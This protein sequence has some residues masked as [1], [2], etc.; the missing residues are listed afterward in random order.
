MASNLFSSFKNKTQSQFKQ[1]VQVTPNVEFGSRAFFDNMWGEFGKQF[2]A[3]A[4]K[5]AKPGEAKRMGTEAAGVV[6]SAAALT[7]PMATAQAALAPL[8][9]PATSTRTVVDM[10]NNLLSPAIKQIVNSINIVEPIQTR[11]NVLAGS[12]QGGE[13]E[14]NYLQ[15]VTGGLNVSTATGSDAYSKLAF[16]AKGTKLEGEGIRELFEGISASIRTMNLGTGDPSLIFQAYTQILAKGKLSMEELRQQLGEKFP[17][18]MQVFAKA[19]NVSVPELGTL[20]SKG[21]ILSEDILPKVAKILNQDFGEAAKAASG[22]FTSAM[23][24]MENAGFNLRVKLSDTFSSVFSVVADAGAKGVQAFTNNFDA[25]SKVVGLGLLGASVQVAVGI[26]ALLAAPMIGKHVATAQNFVMSAFTKSLSTLTPFFAGVFI[27]LLDDVLGAKNSVIDNL[28]NGILNGIDAIKQQADSISRT[29]FNKSLFADA[30]NSEDVGIIQNVNGALSGVIQSVTNFRNAI[31]SGV[32]EMGALILMF[33]QFIALG[34][35]YI[36]PVFSNIGNALKGMGTAFKE[37]VTNSDNLKGAFKNIF[38]TSANLGVSALGKL[39]FVALEAAVALGVLALARGDFSDPIGEAFTKS[40]SKIIDN[41]KG[42]E[43]SLKSLQDVGKDV[44]K[45]ITESLNLQSKGAELNLGK[46]LGISADS[47]KTDDLFKA[48]NNSAPDGA[49]SEN[50]RKV[51][52]SRKQEA[53]K[54][55]VGD[56]FSEN[57]RYTTLAQ[58]QVLKNAKD[59]NKF[60]TELQKALTKSSLTPETITNFAKNLGNREAITNITEIDTQIK[61]L[62]DRRVDLGLINTSDSKKQLREVDKQIDDLL[63]TRKSK[64][65]IF[66][67][68]FGGVDDAKNELDKVIKAIDNDDNLP[69]AA[70]RALK[71]PL[72]EQKKQIEDTIKSIDTLGLSKLVKPLEDIWTGV[73]NKLRDADTALEKFQSRL[74]IVGLNNQTNIINAG[75][76]TNASDASIARA[77]TN[78]SLQNTQLQLNATT[79]SQSFRE[80]SLRQLLSVPG[81]DVNESRKKEIDK[82]REDIQKDKQSVA[83][84]SLQVAQGRA[85][86]QKEL[87]DLTK[88]V[89]DYYLNISR[90]AQNTQLEI[91]KLNTQ[92]RNQNMSNRLRSVLSD[93]YDTLIGSIVDGVEQALNNFNSVTDKAL[94]SQQQLLQ[95]SFDIQDAKRGGVELS[96]QIPANI[97]D[98][99]VDLDF[100]SIPSD[101]NIAQ[102]REEV[103]LTIGGSDNLGNSINNVT[104]NVDQLYKNLESVINPILEQERQTDLV[105][106]NIGRTNDELNRAS[107][108]SN[109]WK[110][111]ILP[112]PIQVDSINSSMGSILGTIG[113]LV[114]KTAEWISGLAGAPNLI[115]QVLGLFT[116][117]SNNQSLQIGG[118]G[119]VVQQGLNFL[120]GGGGKAG[121][122]SWVA[123]SSSSMDSDPGHIGDDIFAPIGSK[124]YSPV[125]GTVVQSRVGG[126]KNTDDANPL[127]PGYQPQQLVI[128]K[129][130]MPIEFEGKKITHL[131]MRHLLDRNVEVG[132]KVKMGDLLGTIG[133]AGGKGTQFG[134]KNPGN[135]SDADAAHLHIEYSPAENDQRNSLRD[136]QASRLTARLSQQFKAGVISGQQMTPS[137]PQFNNNTGGVLW[138]KASQFAPSDLSGLTSRGKKAME[139]LKNPN[140]RKVLDAIAIAELGDQAAAKGGYGYLF[141]DTGGKETFN[142]NTLG[143]HPKRRVSAGGHTSSAT[144]RYQT[145][146][147]VWN[148]EAGRLGIKDF[149]PQSQEIMAVSRLMYRQ[150]L[151]QVMRGDIAGAI[152]KKGDFDLAGEWASLEGNPYGQGTVGGK[153]SNFLANVNRAGMPVSIAAN[154]FRSATVPQLQFGVNSG[155]NIAVNTIQQRS[156]AQQANN[157]A[158]QRASQIAGDTALSRVKRQTE[159]ANRDLIDRD[160]ATRRATTDAKFEAIPFPTLK[161]QQLKES[162]E[163]LRQYQDRITETKRNIEDYKR[164]IDQ[165]NKSIPIFQDAIK[166]APDDNTRKSNQVGLDA[167]IASRNQNIESLRV[168]KKSLADQ[169]L[170]FKGKEAARVE[171]AN[172]EEYIRSSKAEIAIQ[173]AKNASVQAYIDSAE[174]YREFNPFDK[175]LDDLPA[176]KQ[177]LAL[178]QLQVETSNKLLQIEEDIKRSGGDS[179]IV[180]EKTKLLTQLEQEYDYKVTQIKL[181]RELHDRELE[182]AR[183]QRDIAITTRFN[184]VANQ[185]TTAKI[186]TVDKSNSLNAFGIDTGELSKL[187]IEEYTNKVSELG[188]NFRKSI[189]EI[190]QDTNL[191]KEQINEL[192]SSTENLNKINLD[193]L[194]QELDNA[195]DTDKIN[196]YSK[197]ID[198]LSNRFTLTRQPILNLRNAQADKYERDGG[199]VFVA[200]ASRRRVGREQEMFNRDQS[201]MQLDRDVLQ[202][203]LK[204]IEV[205]DTEVE[206]LRNSIVEL[207]EIN[208]DNLNNQ[209]KT[210]GV[211]LGDITKNGITQLSQGLAD[212]ITKGGSVGEVFDNLFNNILNQ[213][214]NMGINSLLGGLFGGL[215][216]D[217]GIVGE[218]NSYS[219]NLMNTIKSAA[220][221]ERNLSGKK[222]TLIMAHQGELLVPADRVKELSSMGLGAD[223]LL[224]RTYAY[225]GVVGERSREYGSEMRTGRNNSAIQIEYQSTQIAGQSYVTEE[226]FQEG[227]RRAAEEGGRR[228]AATVENKLSNSPNYRRA[229]GF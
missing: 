148:E 214:L 70:K 138:G 35:L 54:L 168:A 115:Q 2:Q 47:F 187:R 112:I 151:D 4:F 65:K 73:V 3:R 222:P 192:V 121:K 201:L 48:I 193:N 101:N 37:A 132:Q 140:V 128:I 158:Q 11:L 203:K 28:K 157:E 20:I 39:K 147:F 167:S 1:K 226:N 165:A 88:Q 205:P 103:D 108:L 10:L 169:E 9:I 144:G 105:R 92:T 180:A 175:R 199:N 123:N 181:T 80:A 59:I 61:K 156:Q 152:S 155:T 53:E 62:T 216:A 177:R 120:T 117:G 118:L 200:N 16:A 7:A 85:N 67:D 71:A 137:I 78:S 27:D 130:D 149:K 83:E 213:A 23:I 162:T 34:Q 66:D 46:L 217:G 21:A 15:N 60:S 204:G 119:A 93:G 12:T 72:E 227:I 142:P 150:V 194:K 136:A 26:E 220:S 197:V 206:G 126:T 90:N 55:G 107:E 228:G 195:L 17:Q 91:K 219:S 191:T 145:M 106:A 179:N 163:N 94:E 95:S 98:I 13:K 188:L 86:L 87:R 224:N 143:S 97:P 100:S 76:N 111:N 31:P 160:L 208:L 58:E 25:I 44:G 24:R 40:S 69:L 134:S 135:P 202:A 215:F 139:A 210:I 18:A 173:E 56:Y 209:F 68:V 22:N 133:E 74:K 6:F 174:K 159:R 82:L 81:S 154:N 14:L 229:L 8:L 171:K 207:S 57:D 198:N 5:G 164:V 178:E 122:V 170:A 161:Q 131:N 125:P 212:V 43:K 186:G 218:N 113:N 30:F 124:I 99:K 116:G 33:E 109:Q 52:T 223:V 185:L 41:V 183:I 63:K 129:L 166:N 190:K 196:E 110:D 49:L 141:G 89:N 79:Q 50:E 77:T 221:E 127:V 32:V 36:R 75:I 172:F 64:A 45:S 176:I 84:L 146:D 104:G 225:G 96:R 38:T 182:R 153:R 184:D 19:M 102:L 114:M 189:L 51:A 42:I 211:S 29:I